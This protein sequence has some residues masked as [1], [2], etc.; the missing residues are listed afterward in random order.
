MRD[1]KVL[2]GVRRAYVTSK[3]MEVH[4]ITTS[5]YILRVHMHLSMLGVQ[6]SV[7]CNK[8]NL[9]ESLCCTVKVFN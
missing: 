4:I 1:E 3:S 8:L 9:P 5:K 6:A 2:V 7:V